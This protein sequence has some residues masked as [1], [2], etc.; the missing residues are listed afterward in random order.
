MTNVPFFSR[1]RDARKA[2]GLNQAEFAACG[3]VTAASQVNY[4][5]G[6]R[7]PDTAYLEQ[8]AAHGVDVG[9]LLTGVPSSNLAADEAEL[10]LLYKKA[11]PEAKQVLHSVAA[12]A[13]RTAGA[14]GKGGNTVTIGGDVGQSVAGDQTVSA[15]LKFNVGKGRK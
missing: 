7:N 15:P 3:G 8:L 6:T 9:Y 2:L 14:Q 12:L 11:D 1:L 4:E 13:G 5:K 10:L